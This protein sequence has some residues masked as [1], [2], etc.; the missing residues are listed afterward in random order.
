MVLCGH[1]L[2]QDDTEHLECVIGY[3]TL[4]YLVMFSE[5]QMTDVELN[6]R[7]PALE[8]NGKIIELFNLRHV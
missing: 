3:A 4:L 8:E 5:L 6:E 7:V 1:N 2:T